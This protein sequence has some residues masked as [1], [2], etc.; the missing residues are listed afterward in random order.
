[1]VNKSI[2]IK[3]T[4]IQASN[5]KKPESPKFIKFSLLINMKFSYFK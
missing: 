4:K 2:A 1:M 3:I 5:N